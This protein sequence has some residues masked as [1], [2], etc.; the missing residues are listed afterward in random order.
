M[1]RC[2]EP[3]LLDTL[4]PGDPRALRS[5]QDLR[6]VNAWMGNHR[7]MANA[8]T[9]YAQGNPA[10]S[11]IELGAGDGQFLL[12]VA[13]KL[14]LPW[15]EIKAT[16]LDRQL[17]IASST[18]EA[19]AALRWELTA[20]TADVFEWTPAA[21][22]Q[23]VILANLFLHH[24]TDAPLA[25][26]LRKIAGVTRLFVAV[27]PRRMAFPA[28]GGW[29]LALIGCNDVTR[30]DGTVSIRAGFAGRELSGLWPD[31]HRWQLTEKRA[32]LFSHLFIARRLD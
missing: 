25:E 19:F 26:L 23:P 12:T 20:V 3:E 22:S 5:R 10:A 13:R 14:S 17:S 8:L 32:G 29:L 11:I 15:A 31:P 16:L 9:Q 30:H 7:I 28:V 18:S 27:E 4:P 24:F 1:N 21:E 6:R 2:V